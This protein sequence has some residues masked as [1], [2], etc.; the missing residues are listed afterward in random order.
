MKV[1]SIN[2]ALIGSN[3]NAVIAFYEDNFGFKVMH[4]TD[5]IDGL[6]PLAAMF[7]LEN[8]KGVTYDVIQLD[9]AVEEAVASRVNVDNFEDAFAA[10]AALGYAV[11]Y[12]PAIIESATTALLCKNGAAPVLLM[13]HIQK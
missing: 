6:A 2:A 5:L 12:G 1:T 8:E 4:R 9:S 3:A 13:Q 7:T 10:Y 11:A